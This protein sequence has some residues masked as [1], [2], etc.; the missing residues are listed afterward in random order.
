M[1]ASLPS[2]SQPLSGRRGEALRNNTRILDAA[3]A[4]LIERGPNGLMAHVAE[5]AGVGVGSIYRRYATKDRH[6]A[7][8][9]ETGRRSTGCG[10]PRNRWA[11]PR[12]HI[13][14]TSRFFHDPNLGLRHRLTQPTYERLSNAVPA[15]SEIPETSVDPKTNECLSCWPY[16]LSDSAV[17]MSSCVQSIEY[18]V[19]SPAT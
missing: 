14:L 3:R 4:V 17:T 19:M 7:P 18:S 9:R 11:G 5:R 2:S 10:R 13:E 16:R 1:P 15:Q 6:A 12:G 8:S